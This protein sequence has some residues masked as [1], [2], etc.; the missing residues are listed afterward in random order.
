MNLQDVFKALYEGRFGDGLRDYRRYLIFNQGYAPY[1]ANKLV[2]ERRNDLMRGLRCK[3][4]EEDLDI[5][6]EFTRL[7]G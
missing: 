6:A 3:D 1:V 7:L 2:D 4:V 5:K